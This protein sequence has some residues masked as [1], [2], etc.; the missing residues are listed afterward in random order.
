MK[1]CPITQ[2]N[3]PWKQIFDFWFSFLINCDSATS[4]ISKDE[5]HQRRAAH[6]SRGITHRPTQKLK[7]S[8]SALDSLLNFIADIEE[9]GTTAIY[10]PKYNFC[11]ISIDYLN[12]ISTDTWCIMYTI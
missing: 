11:Y 9:Q 10:Y 5:L 2:I 4:S 7:V 12:R 8:I 3:Q 6:N 1:S